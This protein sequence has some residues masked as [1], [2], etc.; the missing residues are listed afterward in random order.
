MERENKTIMVDSISVAETGVIRRRVTPEVAKAPEAPR[1][2]V[3]DPKALI[4][5]FRTSPIYQEAY[6]K[7]YTGKNPQATEEEKQAAFEKQEAARGALLQYGEKIVD[8]VYTPANYTDSQNEAITEYLSK[9]QLLRDVMT[10]GGDQNK[11]V[12]L[13]S[14][15][16]IMHRA[17]GE[18]FA[19]EGI[20]SSPI[21]G[22][23]VLTLIT[24]SQKLESFNAAREPEADRIKRAYAA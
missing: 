2:R 7:F 21:L 16:A 17:G 22:K 15:R 19:K 8:F 24:I 14:E 11:I 1:P 12:T 18:L 5:G 9:V 3:D 20:T 23:T 13:D 10:H 4:N 6:V